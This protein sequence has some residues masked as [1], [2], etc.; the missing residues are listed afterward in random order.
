MNK[1]DDEIEELDKEEK[2]DGD[3]ENQAAPPMTPE[4]RDAGDD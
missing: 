2:S 3:D 1:G 4:P